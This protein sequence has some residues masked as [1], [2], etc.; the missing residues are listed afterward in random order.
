MESAPVVT[1]P[2]LRVRGSLALTLEIPPR[3]GEKAGE[4]APE[5]GVRRP[6]FMAEARRR[7]LQHLADH[8]PA[9]IAEVPRAWPV[10]RFLLRAAA[11]QL[12]AQGLIEAAPEGLPGACRITGAG[13]ALIA[14]R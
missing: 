4:T 7:V 9:T 2:E 13:E 6:D 14:K 1:T 3:P 12:K 5:P 10:S 8:G 11:A